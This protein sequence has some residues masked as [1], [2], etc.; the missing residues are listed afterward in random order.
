MIV[1]SFGRSA[2]AFNIS[3]EVFANGGF[4]LRGVQCE[5]YDLLLP[6]TSISVIDL[7]CGS[8]N[9]GIEVGERDF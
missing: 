4:H 3:E 5:A 9:L 6:S 2:V 1:W 8:H 7:R